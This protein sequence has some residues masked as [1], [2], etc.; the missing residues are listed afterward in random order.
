MDNSGNSRNTRKHRLWILC[1][2]LL[3]LSAA[4]GF[5][6]GRNVHPAAEAVGQDE[7]SQR[8]L[9]IAVTQSEDAYTVISLD[10]LGEGELVYE[11]VTDVNILL[12]GEKIPLEEAIRNRMVSVPE[13]IGWARTDAQNGLCKEFSETD[14]G[15]TEFMYHYIGCN[16][17]TFYDIL[18]APDGSQHLIQRLSIQSP[19]SSCSVK[20]MI[21][22]DDVGNLLDREDWGITLEVEDVTPT[23]ITLRF[24]QSGGQQVGR[25]QTRYYILSSAEIR[26]ELPYGEYAMEITENGDTL[27]TLDWS[28]TW[29]ALPSGTYQISVEVRD[30]YDESQMHPLIRKFHNGQFYGLDFEIP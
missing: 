21:F 1:I 9:W 10:D 17:S 4:G 28:E 19:F 24:T 22:F 27:Y 11:D 25:L 29:G 14:N 20:N 18:D 2:L 8:K 23:G 15:L 6:L 13:L 16:V 26:Q 5:F 30:V 7:E 12:D 3:V